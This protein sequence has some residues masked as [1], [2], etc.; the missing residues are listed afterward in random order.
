MQLLAPECSPALNT[1]S[2]M[3]VNTRSETT[4]AGATETNFPALASGASRVLHTA[5]AIMIYLQDTDPLGV[6]RSTF[7]FESRFK[8]KLQVHPALVVAG[9]FYS[10]QISSCIHPKNRSRLLR[11]HRRMA[12]TQNPHSTHPNPCYNHAS[13]FGLLSGNSG[14]RIKQSLGVIFYFILRA[15]LLDVTRARGTVSRE[16]VRAGL[17]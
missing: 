6:Q 17:N 9:R 1:R 14:P 11:V 4:G 13:I 3:A 8:S 5:F 16:R 7:N 2:E 12:H 10:V 15:Q